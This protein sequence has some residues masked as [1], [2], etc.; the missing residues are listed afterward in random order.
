MALNCDRKSLNRKISS[1]KGL[2]NTEKGCLRV[3]V[4]SPFLEVF[5]EL[6]SWHLR[7]W[8]SGGDR[9]VRLK[10]ELDDLRGLLLP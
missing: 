1:L 7:T 3:V 5:K 2:S 6:W 8:S 9:G 10:V 4:K